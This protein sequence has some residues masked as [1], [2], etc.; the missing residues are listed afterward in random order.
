MRRI[1][2]T[3]M[4]L[5]MPVLA[6]AAVKSFGIWPAGPDAGAS[7]YYLRSACWEAKANCV[8]DHTVV[9]P[10]SGSANET[11]KKL[12]PISSVLS[13]YVKRCPTYAWKKV[14]GVFVVGPKDKALSKL[15]VAVGPFD[16]TS[17]A[18][19]M[20]LEMMAAAGFRLPDGPSSIDRLRGGHETP[21]RHVHFR[22]S[23]GPFLEVLI[24]AARQASPSFWVLE[25]DREDRYHIYADA[26]SA[27]VKIR[28]NR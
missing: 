20:L 17:D 2:W 13:E 27:L 8:L 24:S 28:P 26:G 23:R 5:M 4:S 14:D 6:F 11:E 22:L 21:A 1:A 12:A 19:S 3:L 25:R 7:W 10:C 15:D 16:W 18:R 9:G